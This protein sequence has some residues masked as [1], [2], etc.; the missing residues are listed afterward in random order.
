MGGL[1]GFVDGYWLMGVPK[2][3]PMYRLYLMGVPKSVM[4]KSV[5]L[6]DGCPDVSALFD[7]CPKMFL[8]MSQNVFLFDGCPKMF[9]I[10]IKMITLDIK[11]AFGE[12]AVR[13][14]LPI[15]DR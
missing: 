3:V 10:M 4:P 13:F 12:G 15:Q 7:G 14:R 5:P 11:A 9:W 2:S 6:I 1:T 8:W